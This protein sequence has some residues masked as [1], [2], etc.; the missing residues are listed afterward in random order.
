MRNIGLLEMNESDSYLN[1]Q[2][3][4]DRA[5]Y[6]MPINTEKNTRWAESVYSRWAVRRANSVFVRPKITDYGADD[7]KDLNKA[8]KNFMPKFI[9]WKDQVLHLAHCNA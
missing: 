8:L 1:S 6:A 3:I 4:A 7:Q 9:P 5:K 2:E